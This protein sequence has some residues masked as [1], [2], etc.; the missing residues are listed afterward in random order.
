MITTKLPAGL[1]NDNTT[2]LF[3]ANDRGYC[4]FDGA[5]Q[6]TKNMPSSIKNAVVQ[7]YKNRFG[8]ERAYESM[9]NF[10]EDDKIEQCI[11]C[12]FANF[13]N[14]PDFDALGNITPE[15]VACS[16]RGKCK[17]EGVG[18]LPTVG[19]DKLSPAQKRVAML[20]YKSGKEIAEA[21]FISTN[22]VKRHLSDAMHITGA[23]NSRELIRLIDQS[24]VN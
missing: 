8:A 12:M 15:V 22:T 23:K 20:C 16:K 14:T 3:S 13:D 7:F 21:L 17:H 4:L 1:F 11:K 2:E 24:T 9:G 6:S 19:I 18:C 10:T 5:A